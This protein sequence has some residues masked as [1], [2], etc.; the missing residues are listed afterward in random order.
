MLF[1]HLMAIPFFNIHLLIDKKIFFLINTTLF[2]FFT[3]FAWSTDYHVGGTGAS[4][5]NPGTEISP[6]LT[7]QKAANTVIAGDTVYV[8]AGTYKGF[9]IAN[10]SGTINNPIVFKADSGV[11]I[12]ENA[13]G[14][15]NKDG[16]NLE[17]ASYI[18][19]DG[20]TLV[21]SR[22]SSTSRAGIRI[23]GNGDDAD[24]VFST[25]VIIKNN[26]CSQWG[27]WG[28]FCG[29]S[30]NITIEN[31]EC[32]Q[33]AKE[34][35]IYFSNSADNPI[36]R[37]NK[38]WGNAN[39]GIHINSDIDSGNLANP[40]VD[41]IIKNALIEKNVIY[42]NGDG[43][44]GVFDNNTGGGSAINM[45]G[46]QDSLVQNNLLYENHASGISL[47]R[48]DGADGAKNNTIINNTII[49]AQFKNGTSASRYCL[50]IVGSG[51]PY[52][53]SSGSIIFN[54][55]FYNLG[56]RGVI[57]VD[58]GSR[59]N[60]KCNYNICEDYFLT[61]DDADSGGDQVHDLI[62]WQSLGFDANSIVVSLSQMKALF[63]NYDAQDFTLV[64]N[65]TAVNFGVSSFNAKAAPITDI[66]GKNR[67]ASFD[68]GA[69]EYQETITYTITASANSN[70]SITPSGSISV[71]S[72]NSQNFTFTPNSGFAVSDVIVNGV[73]VGSPTNY[74]FT[75]ITENKTIVVSFSAIITTHLI[76]I[77][78]GANGISSPDSSITVNNGASQ[79]ISFT[80]GSNYEINDII[81]DGV[82][83]GAIASLTL[84]NI[85]ASHSITSSFKL[86]SYTITASTDT[87][88]TISPNGLTTINHGENLE[89]SIVANAGFVI[90]DVKVD[91]ISQGDINTYTF[92][93]VSASHTIHAIFS[94]L[95]VTHTISATSGTNGSIIPSGEIVVENG[96][97]Q[98]FTI[99]P[100]TGFEIDDLKI[101]GIS[102]SAV[103]AYSF[104]NV[105]ANQTI[106]VTFKAVNVTVDSTNDD[107]DSE[108][109]NGASD[110]P[111]DSN[112][113]TTGSTTTTTK[114]G[115]GGGCQYSKEKHDLS[116]ILFNFIILGLIFYRRLQKK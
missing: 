5:S 22:N 57:T 104:T 88:G 75:N 38:I 48:I 94:V 98:S 65:S 106:E 39:A 56:T 80:P 34:H 87:G 30:D 23:V 27:I 47:Y 9:E 78:T 84:E 25:G 110:T 99:T 32:S 29:F 35:G 86:K 92:S 62:S 91:N 40:K 76:T 11:L 4:D 37:G 44:S 3:N 108:G 93:N 46:V 116:L 55:I 45:D 49:M 6:W 113:P 79:T 24:G 20:F 10:K 74:S 13:S 81:L 95:T 112:T 18:T 109:G 77:T 54:N 72:G 8:H 16:I 105:T 70:G 102:Q 73:S 31:N 64:S 12:N 100:H 58:D 17:N 67:S 71:I 60:M 43:Y 50:N 66:L 36:I 26:K 115:S 97:S 85:T 103:A 42:E 14:I 114:G 51:S 68:V 7:L 101:N 21:G 69:Y 52:T 89:Y 1:K 61:V 2:A 19:I 63:T 82:S 41:G 83:Q 53:P 15:H 59:A 33:S 96:S 111:V 28:I 107:S 90:S